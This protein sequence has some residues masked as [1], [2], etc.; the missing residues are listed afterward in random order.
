MNRN[1]IFEEAAPNGLQATSMNPP[2]RRHERTTTALRDPRRGMWSILKER[3]GMVLIAGLAAGV[4]LGC[5]MK[6]K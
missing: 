6:R 3:P 5:W 2:V 1:R 4:L